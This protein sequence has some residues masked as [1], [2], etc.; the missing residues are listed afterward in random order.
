MGARCYVA[1]VAHGNGQP[2]LD[3][4][5]TFDCN[6]LGHRMVSRDAVG[7]ETMCQRIHPGPGGNMRRQTYGKRRVFDDDR[8]QH[9]RVKD[10]LFRGAGFL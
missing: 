1:A 4:T 3:Q 9:L 6:A 5:H 8:W 10:D 2:L 7:L